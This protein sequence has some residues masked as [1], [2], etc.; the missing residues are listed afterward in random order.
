M[1]EEV[2]SSVPSVG[3]VCEEGK[4]KFNFRPIVLAPDALVLLSSILVV[5]ELV[6]DVELLRGLGKHRNR[7]GRLT[8]GRFDDGRELPGP[9]LLF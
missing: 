1:L 2:D 4:G 9:G 3:K 8:A 6:V 5:L 7:V